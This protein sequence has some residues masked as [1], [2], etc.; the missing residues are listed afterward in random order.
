MSCETGGSAPDDVLQGS[1]RQ[2]RMIESLFSAYNSNN[3]PG[4]FERAMNYTLGGAEDCD[5]WNRTYSQSFTCGSTKGQ[6]EMI[7]AYL[8]AYKVTGNK[9]FRKIALNLTEQ[10]IS[11]NETSRLGSALWEASTY[12]N[13]SYR[14][15]SI[16]E[17]AENTSQIFEGF[18]VGNCSAG[19]YIGVNKLF[20][21]S[22]L[23]S[24]SDYSAEYRHT[25]LNTTEEGNCGPYKRDVSCSSPAAQGELTSLM[26]E[27]AYSMPL[28]IKVEDSFNLS[29]DTVTVGEQFSATCS[30]R[31]NLENTTLRDTELN[32][33]VSEG[34][35]PVDSNTSYS[36]GD[37]DFTNSTS[38]SWDIKAVSSGARNVSCALSSESGYRDTITQD[39][40][41]EQQE[42]EEGDDS[43]S[44]SGE[45]ST[46]VFGGFEPEDEE[47][48]RN[49]TVGYVNRSG[50]GWN[51]SF[52]GELG[53]NLTYR[54][55]SQ[56]RNC[57]SAERNI[58]GSNANLTV[59]WSCESYEKVVIDP[60]PENV[61]ADINRSGYSVNVYSNTSAPV[62]TTYEGLNTTSYSNPLLLT[63]GYDK[64]QLRLT[65][66]ST[67]G[68]DNGTALLSA[69]LSRPAECRVLRGGEEVYFQRTAGLEYEV[70]PGYGNTTYRVECGDQSFTRM[71]TRQRPEGS[72]ESGEDMALPLIPLF[73]ILVALFVSAGIYYREEII[74]E[75]EMRLFEYRF[76]KFQDAVN[77]GDTAE[78]IEVFESMSR[79]V[80]Q[81]VIESD[82][83]LMQGLLLY[84]LLDLV[85]EGKED[86]VQFDVSEDLEELVNRYLKDL[87]GSKSARL[88]EEKYEEVMK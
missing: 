35:D 79:D 57:F 85:Q 62:K 58:Q 23:N 8:K 16:V 19:E 2:A 12:F 45:S 1:V 36:A 65:N 52:L 70:S 83:D 34:L 31:N 17:R 59:S 32:L 77:R 28:Q 73:G 51:R 87:E 63:V 21:S 4:T 38:V 56:N 42:Q 76:S 66:I 46:P 22:Y 72:D 5:V 27:S 25:I 43:S 53:L 80:S 44:T 74:E 50:L 11:M 7:E 33:T 49:F 13:E 69:D 47:E 84:L 9:T 18:C 15:L 64:P 41:V 60:V 30:V 67:S 14:N 40:Q 55:F 75:A 61:T 3:G 24:K 88:V 20:R 68:L 81:Q 78:A 54:E 39:I 6:A 10:G 48:R 37:L 86:D 26:W 71:F 82:M 29:K